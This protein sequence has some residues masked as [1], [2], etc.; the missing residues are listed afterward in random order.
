MCCQWAAADDRSA[1]RT[2]GWRYFWAA[3]VAV[4]RSERRPT[5]AEAPVESLA[6]TEAPAIALRESGPESGCW[7]WWG[8]SGSPMTAGAE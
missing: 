2:G 3:A 7:A 5:V 4:G 6:A 8:A 1:P